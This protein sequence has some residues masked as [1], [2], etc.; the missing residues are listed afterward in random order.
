M[1]TEEGLFGNFK[2]CKECGR[3]LPVHYEHD[4]CPRC[5]DAELFRD[6]K[7]YIRS[8][9]VNEYEVAEHFKISLKQVK[10]WIREGRIEYCIDDP[11]ANV[12]SLHCLRCGAPVNFG[13]LC[14]KC[15]KVLNG[16]K[17]FSS[18]NNPSEDSRMRFLDHQNKS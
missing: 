15:L 13:T 10:E 12:S 14:P 5:K 2:H 8:N 7:E 16:N 9:T 17:G 11:S 3:A 6:V 18:D 4:L 1:A